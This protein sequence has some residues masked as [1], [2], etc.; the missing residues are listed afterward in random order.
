MKIASRVLFF[1]TVS[2]PITALPALLPPGAALVRTIAWEAAAAPA[3]AVV[4]PKGLDG[5]AVLFLRKTETAP[6]NLPLWS[7]QPGLHAKCYALHGR[8]KYRDVPGSGYLELW[9]EFSPET[10][11]QPAPKYFSRTLAES[12][13]LGKIAGS[14]D[15]RTVWV[16]FDA[17]QS[18]TLPSKLTLNLVLPGPGEVTLSKL[19]LFEFA[20][21]GAMW[22]AVG[23]GSGAVTTDERRLARWLFFGIGAGALTV[24]LLVYWLRRRQRD[25]R[26]MRAMDLA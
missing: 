7:A 13:P 24:I 10:P 17:T 23:S 8:M 20:D 4:Q 11:G 25:E 26:R 2:A 18:K 22:A 16:P 19:E 15:W 6:M 14:S 9:N 21:A 12:G 3:G 1:L 5:A